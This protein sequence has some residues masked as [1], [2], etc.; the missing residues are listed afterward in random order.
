MKQI[1][2]VHN[3][4]NIQHKFNLQLLGF[5]QFLYTV[6]YSAKCSKKMKLLKNHTSTNIV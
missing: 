6:L 1:G 5:S 3:H 4:T 2:M